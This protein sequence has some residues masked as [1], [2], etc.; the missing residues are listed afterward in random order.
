M[1]VEMFLKS[2]KSKGNIYL[3][4]CSYDPNTDKETKTRIVYGFGRREKAIKKMIEWKKDFRLFPG[5][6]K[7]IGCSRNDLNKWIE[8]L[9]RKKEVC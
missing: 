1:E 6:L 4:L 3:Y 2:V 5:E 7:K 8:K 9:N